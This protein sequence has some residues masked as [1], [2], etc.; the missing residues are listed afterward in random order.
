MYGANWQVDGCSELIA[1]VDG[2]MG[3]IARV[4]SNSCLWLLLPPVYLAWADQHIPSQAARVL[5]ASTLTLG[6]ST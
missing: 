4:Y 3:L 1:T 5:L 6:T 2:C